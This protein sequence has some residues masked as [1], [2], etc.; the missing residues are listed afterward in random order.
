MNVP[1]VALGSQW[2]DIRDE[3]MPLIDEVLSTGMYLEHELVGS[4]E[5]NLASTI[6]VREA[7]LV[8]SGQ[9]I[10]TASHGMIDS[11]EI[12]NLV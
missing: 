2:T 7:I 10:Y 4:L 1:Y 3:A 9:V 11:A 12:Q 6:G 5:E 8:N